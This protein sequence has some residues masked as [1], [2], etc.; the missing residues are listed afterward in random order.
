MPARPRDRREL[1]FFDHLDELRARIIR[2]F[3]YVCVGAAAS[4]AFRDD[5]L[6]VLC[7]PAEEGARRIGVDEL[8]FRLFEPAAGFTI[9]IQTALMAGL[10]LALPFILL[11][12]WRFIEPALEDHERKYMLIIWPFAVAL[13]AAGVIFCYVVSPNAFAF[14]FRMDQSMNAEIELTL[15][16]YLWFTMRLLLAFGAAFELPLVLMFLGFL[17]IV[18]S[19]QLLGWWRHAIVVILLF[20]AIVTP[21]PDPLN[22]AIL[23]APMFVLYLFSV[24]LVKFVQRKRGTDDEAALGEDSEESVDEAPDIPGE[25]IYDEYWDEGADDHAIPPPDPIPADPEPQDAATDEDEGANS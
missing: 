16:P 12:I 17:G 20:A 19:R 10:V 3:V 1:G 5:I 2:S 18:N 7:Y 11:E 8:P 6:A 9:A 13:F 14:L 4:W 25:D 21:T 22:M 23:A 24:V 15:K